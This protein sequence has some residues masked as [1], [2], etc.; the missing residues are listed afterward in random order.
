MTELY[1][2]DPFESVYREV[3]AMIKYVY[4]KGEQVPPEV[5]EHYSE[6]EKEIHEF[7]AREDGE[8]SELGLYRYDEITPLSVKMG[9]VHNILS[10][11]VEPALPKSIYMIEN[12][13]DRDSI[14]TQ[15]GCLPIIRRMMLVSITSMIIFISVSLS[16][17]INSE[18]I[19][20]SLFTLEG[21]DLFLFFLFLL[22]ASALGAAFSSL[23]KASKYI[24][25]RTFDTKYETS[26]W[27]Q[28]LVG[29]ISGLIITELVPKEIFGK[30]STVGKP[31]LALLGGF[32]SDLVYKVLQHLVS[33]VEFA[34]V[35]GKRH[36]KS[37]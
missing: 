32:S 1:I 4:S 3:K 18:N 31:T 22:S 29:L 5:M 24:V 20:Q 23:L 9:N 15:L 6:I 27:V 7:K 14:W 17:K 34:L 26:Y 12:Q 11:M 33:T 8:E 13:L 30:L 10:E 28:L 21:I 19:V 2:D 25:N 36:T 37:A 35:P 16:S